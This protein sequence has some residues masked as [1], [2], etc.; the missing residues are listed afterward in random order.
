MNTVDS[1][2]KYIRL[3]LEDGDIDFAGKAESNSVVNQRRLLDGYIET[4]EDLRNMP[5]MEFVDDGKSGTNFQRS[6]FQ[7]LMDE[8]KRGKVKAVIVKDFSRFGRSYIEVSD[9]L[10]Q[11][12]PFLGVR[13][14]SVNDRYD[15]KQYSYGSAGMIDVGFKQIMHQYY[16]ISLS[17]SGRFL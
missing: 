16:S 2:A 9:Y 15:S 3:S 5:V 14:I 6:G 1:L 12:F 7:S 10:E 13:F 11:I 4:H 17:Q 8:I